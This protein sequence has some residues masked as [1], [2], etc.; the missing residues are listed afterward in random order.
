MPTLIR[1]IDTQGVPPRHAGALEL[2]EDHLAVAWVA[3][4]RAELVVWEPPVPVAIEPP[5]APKGTRS[6]AVKS[7]AK[8]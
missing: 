4:G 6:K 1:W 5:E 3:A 2:V 7:A 8:G